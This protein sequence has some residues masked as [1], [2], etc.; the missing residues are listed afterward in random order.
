VFAGVGPLKAQGGFILVSVVGVS[1]LM[2][3]LA[4]AFN[5]FAERE[6]DGAVRAKRLLE[7]NLDQK[8]TEQTLLYL[9]ATHR[10]T[11]AGLSLVEEDESN[12]I[13]DRDIYTKPV[14]DEMRLDGTPYIG[15]GSTVYYIRD[16]SGAFPLNS[17]DATHLENLL[18]AW[19]ADI[20]KRRELVDSLLDY[21]DVDQIERLHGAEGQ[22]NN[23]APKNYLLRTVPE[24]RRVRGWASWLDSHPDF[25]PEALFSVSW[26]ASINV[27]ALPEEHFRYLFSL[28]DAEL[29]GTLEQR[30]RF[31]FQSV[32]DIKKSSGKE[33]IMGEL[34]FRFFPSNRLRFT[35]MSPD[36]KYSSTMAITFTPFGLKKPWHVEYQYFSELGRNLPESSARFS[37]SHFTHL[38]A[39]VSTGSLPV[40]R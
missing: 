15:F 33:P 24:I 16:L 37:E 34:Y 13:I 2:L 3:I 1:A 21:I 12:Y 6:I 35:I 14:G 7:N 29:E 20:A 26:E 4:G 36:S 30:E 22:T 38:S 11:R 19:E 17:M 8:S 18:A 23:V 40:G 27:N 39:P 9:V 31:A 5:F 25:D 28:T 32:D 10:Y